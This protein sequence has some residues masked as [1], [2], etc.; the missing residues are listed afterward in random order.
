LVSQAKKA[1]DEGSPKLI[2]TCS[3]KPDRDD[4]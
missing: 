2:F 3:T 4:G 1:C